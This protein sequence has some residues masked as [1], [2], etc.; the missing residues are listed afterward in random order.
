VASLLTEA[1]DRATAPRLELLGGFRLG[2]SGSGCGL[3]APAKRVVAYLALHEGPCRRHVIAEALWP[4]RLER[5]SSACLRQAL[6]HERRAGHGLI[7][8]VGHELTLAAGVVVDV[9]QVSAAARDLVTARGAAPA[10]GLELSD[11]DHDLLPDWD[12][13]WLT[14]DRERFRELRLHALEL[15]CESWLQAGR[16]G[17]AIDAALRAVQADPL[18]ESARSLLI[19]SYLAEGNRSAALRSYRSYRLLLH[20][21]LGV[22]PPPALTELLR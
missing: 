2:H 14:L 21:E 3:P 6:Q 8:S 11:L 18:R 4:A 7:H 1:T 17:A 16:I 12:E 13:D 15:L 5:R 10:A 20:E 22:E 9:R 19:R